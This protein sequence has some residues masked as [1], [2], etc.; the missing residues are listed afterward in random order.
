MIKP[1]RIAVVNASQSCEPSGFLFNKAIAFLRMNRFEVVFDAP[2]TSETWLINTC[3]V[4]KAKILEANTLIRKVVEKEHAVA[5]IVFG[6]LAHFE[7]EALMDSRICKV[8]PKEI[9]RL[10]QIFQHTISI[11][12]VAAGPLDP[13]L[14]VPYQSRITGKDYF[15]LISQG[16]VHSCSYCNIKKVKGHVVSRSS[17][18]IIRD[19]Q[20]GL[21]QGGR[22]FVLLSDDCGSYGVDIGSDLV[23]LIREIASHC[24]KAYLK[25]STF[26]PGDFIRL[27]PGLRDCIL[28]GNIIYINVPIQS[29][30]KRILRLMQREYKLADVLKM[31]REIKRKVPSVWLYT[32]IL[33]N[34]PTETMA[35]YKQS[36]RAAMIFDEFIV[37]TYSDNPQT[38]ANKIV[39]KVD[40]RD[41][42]ERLMLAKKIVA[43]RKCGMVLDGMDSSYE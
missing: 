2:E 13:G 26:H 8:G 19:I 29:G 5:I 23:K 39:P 20:L 10:D 38:T 40:R 41:Q 35:D 6:C 37:I 22:E 16:C 21:G 27:Y 3:C 24:P 43:Y 15:V 4:T 42:D 9:G 12:D 14:F 31:M 11:K 34:F 32:H 30:S 1:G 7:K 28:N 17:T 36:L 33:A 18:E 25:I